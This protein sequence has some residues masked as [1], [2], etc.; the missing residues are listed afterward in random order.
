MTNSNV[1]QYANM[2]VMLE[3]CS[4]C[5][6]LPKYGQMRYT[7]LLRDVCVQSYCIKSIAILFEHFKMR[8]VSNIL[9]Q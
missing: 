2:K 1:F 6:G 5:S 7:F 3:P 8:D 9:H 4:E